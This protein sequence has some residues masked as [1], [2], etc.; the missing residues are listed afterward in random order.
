MQKTFKKSVSI[1]LAVIMILS[2]FTIV[3]MSAGATGSVASVNGVEFTSFDAAVAGRSSE[4]DVITLLANYSG[5]YV[6]TP[7]TLKVENNGFTF[8]KPTVEGAYIVSQTVA[9]DVSTYTTAAATVK[10]TNLAGTVVTYY[11]QA[12]LNSLDSGTYQ[13]LADVTRTQR[14]AYGIFASNVT[15]DLNGH[16]L[17]SSASDYAITLGRAGSASSPKVFALVDTSTNG[18]GKLVFTTAPTTSTAAIR[19]GAKYNNITIGEGATVEGGAVALLSANQSLTVNGTINGGND[20]AIVTNG[21]SS[22]DATITINNDAVVSSNEIAMYL[23]APG[24]CTI[25]GGTITGDTA[26]YIKTGTL[27]INGGTITG[28]GAQ[29]DYSYNGNGANATGDA[30]VADNCNYGGNGAPAVTITG[31]T[32]TSEHA[33]AIGAYDEDTTDETVPEIAVSGG[34]FSSEVLPE[35]CANGFVPADNGNSTYGVGGPYAAKIGTAGYNTLAEAL[36]AVQEN[37][38][39]T[40]MADQSVDLQVEA[41]K[42]FTIDLNS[43]KMT[44]TNPTY[45]YIYGDLTIKDNSAAQTGAVDVKSYGIAPHTDG[46]VTVNGGSFTNDTHAYIFYLM[47]GELVV[48]RGS[49]IAPHPVNCYS[50]DNIAYGGTVV[51]NGG[52]FESTEYFVIS[53]F[54]NSTITINDGEFEGP[55]PVCVGKASSLSSGYTSASATITGGTFTA[56]EYGDYGNTIVDCENGASVTIAGGTFSGGEIYTDDNTASTVAVSGGTFVGTDVSEYTTVATYQ[57]ASG[58]VVEKAANT[59]YDAYDFGQAAITG[60]NWYIVADVNGNGVNVTSNLKIWNTDKDHTISGNITVVGGASIAKGGKKKVIFTGTVTLDGGS[61]SDA[62]FNE[63]VVENDPYVHGQINNVPS[64]AIIYDGDGNRIVYDAISLTYAAKNG[65]EV[66]LVDDITDMYMTMNVNSG[67]FT[68][69]GNGH[70]VNF[71][72]KGNYASAI[73]KTANI[74]IDDLTVTV[75]SGKALKSFIQTNSTDDTTSEVI[76]DGVSATGFSTD[77]VYTGYGDWTFTSATVTSA[78]EPDCPLG[79]KANDNEDGTWTIEADDLGLKHSIS[80]NGDV[81]LNFYL[82]P[83]LVE[84]GDTINFTWTVN[85]EEKSGSYDVKAADLDPLNGYKVSV[86]LPAAEMTSTVRATVNNSELF[87]DYSVRAYCDVILADPDSS[88]ELVDLVKT[89]LNYGAM[90]QEVWGINLSAKANDNIDYTMS[91]TLTNETIDNAIKAANNGFACNLGYLTNEFTSRFYTTSLSFL[92][93]CTLRHY[94]FNADCTDDQWDGYLDDGYFC[95]VE[96]ENIAAA[97]LDKLYDFTVDGITFQYSALDYV[98][99]VINNDRMTVNAKNL[100]KA[101]FWYN[102]AANAFFG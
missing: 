57:N 39:I 66:Y 76:I 38:T 21:A 46:K 10:H 7:G 60:G 27:N 80:L 74:A 25:N 55:Y 12:N 89:M 40:L 65:S 59:I 84:V 85:G 97:D 24:I 71:T 16:T 3:P 62:N 94:F 92:S 100:A 86:S 18:G 95:Y 44:V 42:K 17:T 88:E 99:E 61:V 15:L 26:I 54:E 83:A 102:Q 48:N 75:A 32:L 93:E 73:G 33:A 20:F 69:H 23:P 4:D 101:T 41:G 11:T 35:Y 52:S 91:E 30:I 29:A 28:T 2:V 43:F 14:M 51:I 78:T 34:T 53:G 50:Y 79:W 37:E 82:N 6:M 22:K 9:D 98:K 81:A 63:I 90:A 47:G 70:T 68:L 77:A 58:E 31:G 72:I 49:F 87:D 19:A 45:N 1:L 64:G 8:A 67:T 36:G 56:T 13:L 96:Q 5:T